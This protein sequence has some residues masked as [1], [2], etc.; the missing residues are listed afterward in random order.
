MT[1]KTTGNGNGHGHAKAKPVEQTLFEEVL[2]QGEAMKDT[3][4]EVAERAMDEVE[5]IPKLIK[6][7]PVQSVLIGFGLGVVGGIFLRKAMEK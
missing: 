3:V 6:K 2:E 7:Y 5:N 1:Q 4:R